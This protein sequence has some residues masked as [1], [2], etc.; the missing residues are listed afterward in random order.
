MSVWNNIAAAIAG[1]ATWKKAIVLFLF[2]YTV[3]FCMLGW[4]LPAV[5]RYTQGMKVFDM[6]PL[7]YSYSYAVSLLETLGEKGKAAYLTRQLPLDF[8]YPGAMGLTGAVMLALLVNR[9]SRFGLLLIGLPLL[10]ASMDYMENIM[11]VTMLGQSPAPSTWI[12]SAASLFTT[13]KSLLSTAYYSVLLV[14][15]AIRVVQSIR[16]RSGDR[17]EP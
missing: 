9:K 5:E 6:Q 11:I 17:L 16:Q 8:I 15:S 1:R 13:L 4:T 7:G 12:V 14:L 2:T 3:Y 10:A